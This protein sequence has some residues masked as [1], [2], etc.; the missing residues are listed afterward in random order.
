MA[1][2]IDNGIA[3]LLGKKNTRVSKENIMEFK[4]KILNFVKANGPV[5]PVQV[6]KALGSDTLFTSAVLSELVSYGQIFLTKAKIGGSP[7]YYTKGQELKLQLLEKYLGDIP[8]KAFQLLRD[9]KILKDSECTPAER[10]ALR[11]LNDFA[12]PIEI[13]TNTYK[14]SNTEPNKKEI[15]WRWYLFDEEEAKKL[16]IAAMQLITK[17]A[18]TSPATNGKTIEKATTYE[19]PTDNQKIEDKI[20]EKEAAKE[21]ERLLKE[22]SE[23]EDKKIW[24]EEDTSIK[25]K[26]TKQ[27]PIKLK[28]TTESKSK[29]LKEKTTKEKISKGNIKNDAAILGEFGYKVFEFLKNNGIDVI[30]YSIIKKNC[31][32]NLHAKLHST[33]GGL[34]YFIKAKKKKCISEADIIS[35]AVEAS[36]ANMPIM[37]LSNGD[38]SGKAAK[39]IIEEYKGLVFKKI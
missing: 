18:I 11:E 20:D 2:N 38:L 8:K 16:A 26:D 3:A 30:D 22:K 1:G 23:I 32:L 34:H 17:P 13:E 5:L 24:S 35:A 29:K 27:K 19:Q 7:L 33:I 36:K 28:E 21:A 15:F 14:S 31:E 9:K 25:L 12:F 39:K 10:V 6:S 4:N 37:F